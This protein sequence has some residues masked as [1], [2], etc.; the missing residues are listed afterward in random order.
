MTLL[1]EVVELVEV[2]PRDGLQNETTILSTV[3]KVTLIQRLEAAGA[4]RIEVA[5][6][7]NPRK[8][9]QMADAEAVIAALPASQAIRIG[10]VLNR[11]GAERALATGIDQLG[12]VCLASDAFGLA[13]QGQTSAQSVSIAKDIVAVALAAGRTAQITI[14]VAFGCPFSGEV[15]PEKVVAIARNVAAS[16]AIEIV[17]ADTIGCAVPSQV[18]HLVARVVAAIK[19]LPVRAHFHETRGTGIANVWAAITA[20]ARTIDASVG[21][22]GGC[23]FAPGSA[24][25]VATEDIAWMLSR[26]SIATGIDLP[27]V[28]D[29]ARWLGDH[30]IRPLPSRVSRAPIFPQNA[31]ENKKS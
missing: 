30:L 8:V 4:R 14:A 3:D 2:G 13:N 1:P 9:P 29:T 10:L 28:I 7:V 31:M 24:G 26:S 18:K 27:A 20:G 15:D 16:G 12:A 5:S 23:P 6:F 21:G 11:R 19:P 17:L 22:F 25:N